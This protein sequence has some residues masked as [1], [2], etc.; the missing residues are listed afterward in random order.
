MQDSDI[1]QKKKENYAADYFELEVLS[2]QT[3]PAHDKVKTFQ[4]SG[5]QIECRV[6]F[7]KSVKLQDEALC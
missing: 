2:T 6:N 7:T 1:V 4:A 5:K 3:D